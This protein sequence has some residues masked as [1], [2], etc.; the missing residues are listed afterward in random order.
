VSEYGLTSRSTHYR[1][2]Q[3]RSSRQSQA[4]VRTTKINSRVNQTNTKKPKTQ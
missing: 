2:Y 3:R 1:S 4:L